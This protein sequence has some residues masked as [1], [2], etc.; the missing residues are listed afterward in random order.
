MAISPS[1][2]SECFVCNKNM[3]LETRWETLQRP[4]PFPVSTGT[5]VLELIYYLGGPVK[6]TQPQG[7]SREHTS[8]PLTPVTSGR[9]ITAGSVLGCMCSPPPPSPYIPLV[10]AQA[11]PTLCTSSALALLLVASN[12]HVPRTG[13]ELSP[14]DMCVLTLRA[15]SRRKWV[16]VGWALGVIDCPTSWPVLL[17]DPATC[18]Q[19][20][21]LLQP[22]LGAIPTSVP[23]PHTTWTG[24]SNHESGYNLSK[25]TMTRILVAL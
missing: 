11:S 10:P 15:N 20:A 5:L 24:P 25:V 2:D 22:Q 14:T 7:G 23:R 3:T 4:G 9:G 12:T 16:T 1:Q 6:G 19:A 21:S 13:C 17:T 8:E 18:E